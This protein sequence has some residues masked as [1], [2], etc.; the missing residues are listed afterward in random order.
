VGDDIVLYDGE[1]VPSPGDRMVMIPASML[2]QLQRAL[3]LFDTMTTG[4]APAVSVPDPD[5]ARDPKAAKYH[6]QARADATRRAYKQGIS[7]YLDFCAQTGRRELPAR[8]STVEAFAIWLSEREVTRGRNKGR[9]G[10]APNSIRLYLSAVCTY[11]RL[12]GENPPDLTLAR[13]IVEGHAR[14]RAKD[15]ASRDGKGVP[16]LRLPSLQQIFEVCDPKTNQ[17]ARDR[18]LLM[19]G[20]AMMARRSE[21]ANLD[22]AHVELTDDGAD[23]YV[24][25]SKTDQTAEGATVNLVW[26]PD[27]K[28]MCPIVN[29]TR[30]HERLAEHGIT[31]GGFLRGVDRHDR[32]NGQ[33]GWAGNVSSRMDPT[34]VEL[35]IARLAVKAHIKDATKMRGHSLRRGGATDFY[36]GGA[37]ILAIAR[38]GRWNE[39]SPVIFRY[40]EEVPDKRNPLRVAKFGKDEPST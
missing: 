39:K 31:E 30:W 38:H 36:D 20:W 17:G 4:Q 28:E 24:R 37:D 27:L 11:H 18:A 15:P 22:I 29:I 25:M 14:G 12:Q 32:I 13:G 7:Y 10:M 2:E 6:R 35:V 9:I 23:I 19:L 26:R 8:A 34:T 40:I 3:D 5:D 1:L 33:P 21:L 16:G